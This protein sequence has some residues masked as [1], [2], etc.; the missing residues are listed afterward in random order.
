MGFIVVVMLGIYV[1]GG[2]SVVEKMEGL[3]DQMK[4]FFTLLERMLP[5][6][7]IVAGF[8]G[9]SIG[10]GKADAAKEEAVGRV[11]SSRVLKD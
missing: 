2:E 1:M 10:Q 5:F 7:G 6:L 9:F 8:F 3:P 11:E 4:A